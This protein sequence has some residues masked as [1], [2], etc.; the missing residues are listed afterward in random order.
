MYLYV[1]VC[2]NMCGCRN[3]CICICK[4]EETMEKQKLRLF[5]TLSVDFHINSARGGNMSETD[6]LKKKDG[7]PN[8]SKSGAHFSSDS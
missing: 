6:G 3:I 4:S 7:I 8:A 5:L 1:Y 2:T